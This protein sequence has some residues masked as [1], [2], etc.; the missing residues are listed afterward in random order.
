M[1]GIAAFLQSRTTN[2]TI[3]AIRRL[4]QLTKRMA[5]GFPSFPYRRIAA[6]LK[7]GKLRLDL[8]AL[9]T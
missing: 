4:L 9:P 8:P 7:A 3:E 1:G 6:F 2:G 5:R